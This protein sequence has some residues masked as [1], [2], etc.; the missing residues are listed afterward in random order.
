MASFNIAYLF[1]CT[2]EGAL[3]DHPSDYGGQTYFGI[4]RRFWP[5]WEGWQYVDASQ[6]DL[7]KA[8]VP[9]FYKEEY[10]DTI[11]GDSIESQIIANRLLEQSVNSNAMFVTKNLQEILNALATHDNAV[12][13][14]DGKMGPATIARLNIMKAQEK[15]IEFALRSV[16]LTFLLGRA[17]ENKTQRVFTLGWINREAV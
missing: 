11:K 3:S 2:K 9:N 4:A 13:A 14:E 7:A 12:I 6:W 10:W 8:A 17:K 15:A 1:L 16:Y 5:N